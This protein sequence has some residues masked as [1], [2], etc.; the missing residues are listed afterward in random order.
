M[1]MRIAEK[2]ERVYGTVV[3]NFYGVLARFVAQGI[4]P[5]PKTFWGLGQRSL[6]NTMLDRIYEGHAVLEQKGPAW[7]F[8][9]SGTRPYYEFSPFPFRKGII[10]SQRLDKEGWWFSYAYARVLAK[11]FGVRL[12][13]HKARKPRMSPLRHYPFLDPLPL[14]A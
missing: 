12:H 13:I 11:V 9:F 7:F 4:A 2:R 6:V 3:D 10:L 1:D 14:P 8:W 5:E